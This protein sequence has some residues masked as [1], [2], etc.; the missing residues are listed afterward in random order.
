MNILFIIK[1]IIS[2][3][4]IAVVTEIAKRNPIMGGLIAA[5]PI[6]TLISVVWLYYE[7]KD[8]PLISEFMHSVFWGMFPTL[9]FFIPALFLFKRGINFYFVITLCFI[10][11]GIGII[12]Y[13][14]LVH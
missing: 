11:L 8:L 1:T 10:S 14:R 7:K 6:T 3:L 2:A 4:I 9:L 12:F 5:M 13:K